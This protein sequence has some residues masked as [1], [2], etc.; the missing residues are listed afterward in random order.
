MSQKTQVILTDDLDGSPADET[1]RFTLDGVRYEIDLTAAHAVTLRELLKPFIEKGR[2]ARTG[3][4]TTTR[5]T[6]RRSDGAAVRA[7]ATEQGIDVPDRGRLSK[8]VIDAYDHRNDTK[9]D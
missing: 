2:R 3:S 7:W 5:S 1:V 8:K 6:S 4:R 9:E